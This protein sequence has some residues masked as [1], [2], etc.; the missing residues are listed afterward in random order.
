M[1]A[2]IDGDIV[3]HRCAWT[4]VNDP[5]GIAKYRANEMLE[6]IL[7]KTGAT[8]YQVWLSDAR[9]NN[10]RTHLDP[11]YKANRTQPRPPHYEYLKEYVIAE[12]GARIAYEMEADDALGIWQRKWPDDT[13]DSN[14]NVIWLH[15]SPSVICSIDKDLKQI[16]G[17]HYDF[18]K[19]V[20]EEITPEE[21]R[22]RF[23]TQM[24]TGDST[25]NIFGLYGVGP[26]KAD[27]ILESAGP[28]YED[29]AAFGLVREAYTKLDRRRT[30]RE[31]DTHLL[32]IGR[33][34]KIKQSE[35]E[36]LW[37]F[38]S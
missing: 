4:T 16:P 13:A 18:V 25:D 30:D 7:D 11:T 19:D 17:K 29:G 12:W 6:G 31:I 26:V 20:H 35:G 9:E 33:L 37:H 2:L 1:L 36:E 8:E 34:L 23:Y 14:V 15:A 28:R 3:V 10:F 5:K 32:L 38:P 22:R 27:R 21:A 24:L